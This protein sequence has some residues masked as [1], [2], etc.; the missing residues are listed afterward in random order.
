ML[1]CMWQKRLFCSNP[2]S[3]IW[4][5]TNFENSL[6]ELISYK[7]FMKKVTTTIFNAVQELQLKVF[8]ASS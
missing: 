4:S 8:M 6:F 5:S 7:C 2:V 1:Y 3:L